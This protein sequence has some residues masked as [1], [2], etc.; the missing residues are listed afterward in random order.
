MFTIRFIKAGGAKD[1]TT[2]EGVIRV[3]IYLGTALRLTNL[4]MFEDVVFDIEYIYVPQEKI[5]DFDDL[6]APT[7]IPVYKLTFNRPPFPEQVLAGRPNNFTTFIS[8]DE[9]ERIL[10]LFSQQSEEE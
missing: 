10:G 8:L 5:E 9:G 2:E 7:T 3:P 1:V 4:G 6:K